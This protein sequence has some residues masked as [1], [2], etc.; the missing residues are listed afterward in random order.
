MVNTSASRLMTTPLN[1]IFA[2]LGTER[3]VIL[4]LFVVCVLLAW[5]ITAGANDIKTASTQPTA[6]GK[7]FLMV[8]S[9]CSFNTQLGMQIAHSQRV[10]LLSGLGYRWG[11]KKD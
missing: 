1:F 7:N 3:A 4:W 5:P 9:I 8:I 6:I 10:C 2:P 11:S